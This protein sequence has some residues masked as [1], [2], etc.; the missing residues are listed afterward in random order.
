MYLVLVEVINVAGTVARRF[1][2][3]YISLSIQMHDIILGIQESDDFLRYKCI[4]TIVEQ[5]KRGIVPN[6]NVL[7]S[8][9]VDKMRMIDFDGRIES[10]NDFEEYP[11]FFEPPEFSVAKN[12]FDA[13]KLIHDA[14]GE[15]A[16]LMVKCKRSLYGGKRGRE[17]SKCY[18]M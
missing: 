15:E 14:I 10:N 17:K 4:Q 12:Y 18:Q 11:E 3:K 13:S 1:S 8:V 6:T 2:D 7:K 9:T 5:Y 16:R